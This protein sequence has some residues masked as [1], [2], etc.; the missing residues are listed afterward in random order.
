MFINEVCF[1]FVFLDLHCLQF[2][3]ETKK[4]LYG[5][6]EII[7]HLHPKNPMT[8]S[9]KVNLIL[10]HHNFLGDRLDF[11]YIQPIIIEAINPPSLDYSIIFGLSIK[12]MI[13]LKNMSEVILLGSK[14]PLTIY[15]GKFNVKCAIEKPHICGLCTKIFFFFR[16]MFCIRFFISLDPSY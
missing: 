11:L 10:S 6:S 5:L 9:V 2:S 4:S 8:E 1:F 3:I 13:L 16:Y 15:L 12:E 7:D 14:K